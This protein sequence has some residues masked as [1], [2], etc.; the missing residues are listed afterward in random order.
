[1]LSKRRNSYWLR[2]A[3]NAKYCKDKET[4]RHTIKDILEESLEHEMHAV[5]LYKDLLSLLR[6]DQFILKNMQ[7]DWRRGATL[8]RAKK[9]LKDFG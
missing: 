7:E 2:W 9:K 1:M 8:F 4:N 3:S 6:I 5:D